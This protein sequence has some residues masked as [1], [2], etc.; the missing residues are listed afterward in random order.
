MFCFCWFALCFWEITY[1]KNS[2]FQQHLL[3]QIFRGWISMWRK[4]KQLLL[5]ASTARF[6]KILFR[7]FIFERSRETDQKKSSTDLVSNRCHNKTNLYPARSAPYLLALMNQQQQISVIIWIIKLVSV[8]TTS[9][10]CQAS[11]TL[12]FSQTK[13]FFCFLFNKLNISKRCSWK[14]EFFA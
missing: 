1:A 8:R 11:V 12:S 9:S 14:I 3:Q 4:L 7:C 6:F 2:V 13:G 10:K 5:A